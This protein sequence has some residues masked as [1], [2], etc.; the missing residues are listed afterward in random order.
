MLHMVVVSKRE[1]S[2]DPPFDGVV[3]GPAGSVPEESSAQIYDMRI[4][5]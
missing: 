3:T 2:F 1:T 4:E 5:E